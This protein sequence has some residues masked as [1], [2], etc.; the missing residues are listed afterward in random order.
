MSWSVREYYDPDTGESPSSR[1]ERLALY[2][3]WDELWGLDS[4]RVARGAITKAITDA[5]D[6]ERISSIGAEKQDTV[7]GL[8]IYTITS[9]VN[10]IAFAVNPMLKEICWLDFFNGAIEYHRQDLIERCVRVYGLAT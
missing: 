4:L 6:M 5:E 9:G 2:G 10:T 1:M 7:D 8:V 3:E